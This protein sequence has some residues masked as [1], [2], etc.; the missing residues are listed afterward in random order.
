MTTTTSHL[1]AHLVAV[2]PR[3]RHALVDAGFNQVH[4]LC[5]LSAADLAR[6]VGV[7]PEEA[8]AVIDLAKAKAVGAYLGSAVEF[9]TALDLYEN[10]PARIPLGVPRLDASMGGGVRAGQVTEIC[11]P[12]GAGKTQ[13]S[14]LLAATAIASRPDGGVL[15]ID[16]EGSFVPERVEEIARGILPAADGG[17]NNATNNGVSA[18]ELLSR[19]EYVRVHSQVEQLALVSDLESHLEA[20]ANIGL[21]ILDSIAFHL[22][23][24]QGGDA[25][26]EREKK[27][28]ALAKMF[29]TLTSLARRRSC[30]VWVTNHIT[31]RRIGEDGAKIVPA[32]GDLWSHVPADRFFVYNNDDFRGLL[33]HKSPSSPQVLVNLD[34]EL[35]LVFGRPTPPQ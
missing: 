31:V 26:S 22:R 17:R 2:P 11:G 3:V 12:P 10:P 27:Q 19:I 9:R 20:R 5:H 23:A 15:Y 14:M 35:P 1:D 13:I 32:L 33:L 25:G 24:G 28:H 4:D 6:E 8:Q 16:T 18:S 30:A 34:E 7:A 29:Q 21:V